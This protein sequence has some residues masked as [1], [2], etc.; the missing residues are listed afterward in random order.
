MPPQWRDV[1]RP[2]H[3]LL[4]THRG[5]DAGALE[6]ARRLA[7]RLDAPLHAATVTRLLVDLNRHER[8]PAVF[9]R[10]TAELPIAARRELVAR[11]HRPHRRAV[12]DACAAA[13]AR[14]RAVLHVAVHSFTPVLGGQ[15][16]NADV[17]LLY[18]PGRARERSFAARWRAELR[19]HD[20]TLRVRMN[21]PYRGSS[22]GLTRWLRTCFPERR[23]AGLELELNQA[24]LAAPPRWRSAMA[25]VEASLRA[26]TR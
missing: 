1:L 8:S 9:S 10:W 13:I 3:A 24:L 14:G 11:W 21:Y 6:L 20:P 26:A 12:H 16:R 7:A 15:T 19:E 22:D 2:A 5:F 17:G 18:D 4:T 23:Y 25:A